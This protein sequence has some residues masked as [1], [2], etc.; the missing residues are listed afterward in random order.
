MTA[1][2]WNVS[3]LHFFRGISGAKL[4]FFERII[5][6][7]PHFFKGMERIMHQ[8]KNIKATKNH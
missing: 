1:R 6:H 5:A 3:S 7:L 8:F 2:F 4:H